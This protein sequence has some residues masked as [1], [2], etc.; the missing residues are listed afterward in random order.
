M[1]GGRVIATGSIISIYPPPGAGVYAATKTAVRTMIEVL[2]LELGPRGVTVNSVNPGPVDGA[3]IF[4]Q[5]TEK[6][7][8]HFLEHT[9][10][11][12]L[13]KLE[14]LVGSFEFLLSDGARMITGQHLAITGG[15]R[16]G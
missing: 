4:T 3:G 16:I 11:S 12:V 2:S 9:P 10:L 8:Q 15:F 13:P 5:M 6:L 14:D 7:H 1:D